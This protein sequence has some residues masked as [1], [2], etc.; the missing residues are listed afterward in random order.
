MGIHPSR[1]LHDDLLQGGMDVVNNKDWFE[2]NGITHVVSICDCTPGEDIIPSENK[3]HI[4]V[5]DSPASQLYPH[6]VRTTT[7]IHNARAGGGKVFVH[8][9][10]GISRSSTIT[11]AYLMTWLNVPFQE[12]LTDLRLARQGACPNDGFQQQLRKWEQS[13]ERLELVKQFE[14]ERGAK[15]SVK[16]LHQSDVDHLRERREQGANRPRAGYLND[17]D[18]DL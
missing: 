6:F 15:Q 3:I 9:A 7:F 1:I 12:A 11:I 2:K 10:A 5:D 4:D 8:C 17:D 13:E 18:D 16:E 14:A